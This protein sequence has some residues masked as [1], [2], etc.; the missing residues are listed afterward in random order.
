MA[1]MSLILDGAFCPTNLP[2]L[3]EECLLSVRGS[4]MK[5][6]RGSASTESSGRWGR[7]TM[8]GNGLLPQQS[9]CAR[10]R[11]E[12]PQRVAGIR[13]QWSPASVLQVEVVPGRQQRVNGELLYLVDR[14]GPGRG[15]EARRHQVIVNRTN[16]LRLQKGRLGACLPTWRRDSGH[17]L[18][19]AWAFQLAGL[20]QV[21]LQLH[22]CP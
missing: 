17:H 15:R 7:Q 8:E 21:V 5:V 10:R 12:G 3:H 20:V 9:G 6:S 11:I 19:D 1:Q 4:S 2:L 13:R 22:S 16:N 14:R 18:L